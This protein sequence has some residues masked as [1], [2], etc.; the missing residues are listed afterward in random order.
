MTENV[1]ETA[2]GGLVGTSADTAR[3]AE[4]GGSR[5]ISTREIFSD[6]NILY[7]L[8]S[9]ERCGRIYLVQG[10]TKVCLKKGKG[11]YETVSK[12]PQDG[13]FFRSHK[14]A[15]HKNSSDQDEAY[16]QALLRLRKMLDGYQVLGTARDE[17]WEKLQAMTTLEFQRNIV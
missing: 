10:Y 12:D 2:D 13:K 6:D 17:D 14:C 9:R 1:Q 11:I 3:V 15:A 8:V 7:Q 4:F 5:R 16:G